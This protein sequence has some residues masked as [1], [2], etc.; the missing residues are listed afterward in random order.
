MKL[1]SSPF[2]FNRE[3]SEHEKQSGGMYMPIDRKKTQKEKAHK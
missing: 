2:R 1:L 3:A